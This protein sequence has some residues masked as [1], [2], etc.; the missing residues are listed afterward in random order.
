MNKP[1]ITFGAIKLSAAKPVTTEK[2]ADEA[3]P[4]GK[5]IKN[6]NTGIFV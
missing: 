2:P 5:S 6:Q 4:S 3:E 1:K